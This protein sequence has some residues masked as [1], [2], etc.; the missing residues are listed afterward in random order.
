MENTVN[1]RETSTATVPP[2]A[3]K[4]KVPIQVILGVVAFVLLV[5]GG[6]V[7]FFLSQQSQDIRQQA[8]SSYDTCIAGCNAMPP[9]QAQGQ[10]FAGCSTANT[11]TPSTAPIQTCL[12][13]LNQTCSTSCGAG[14]IA[15]GSGTCNAGLTCCKPNPQTCLVVSGQTCS[16]SCGTGYS[17]GTG[18]CGGGLTCCK[19]DP[20]STLCYSTNSDCI[21]AGSCGSNGYN[22][23]T[24]AACQAALAN[25]NICTASGQCRGGKLCTAADATANKTTGSGAS[26]TNT[27]YGVNNQ[28]NGPGLCGSSD[29]PLPDRATCLIALNGITP[30]CTSVGLCI[31]Y[32]LCTAADVSKAAQSTTGSGAIC[33]PEVGQCYSKSNNCAATGACGATGGYIYYTKAECQTTTCWGTANEC[34]SR[35]YSC[36][37]P[38]TYDNINACVVALNPQATSCYSRTNNCATAGTCGATGGYIYYTKADCQ[39]YGSSCATGTKYCAATN[40]CI[41]NSATCQTAGSCVQSQG[42]CEGAGATCCGGLVCQGVAGSR[43]CQQQN[44][45]DCAPTDHC[46]GN[47]GYIGFHCTNLTNGQCNSNPQTFD[48]MEAAVAYAGT[49]GQADT[50]CAAQRNLCGGFTIFSSGC[51]PTST[52]PPASTPPGVTP[53]PIGPVCLNIAMSKPNPVVGDTVTFTCGTVAGAA[54]YEFRVKLPDGTI[55]NLATSTTS[56]NVSTSFTVNSSGSHFAQCRLCTGA[57]E[58]TCQAYSSI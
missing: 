53:T 13:S 35:T 41:A 11:P 46:G 39:N 32:H 51:T 43:L 7:A 54:R 9:G 36:T 58:S 6:G 30:K 33:T 22:Y 18:T 29:F 4:K 55:Q 25:L 10:C 26:C 12:Q 49:C 21:P 48:T 31:N 45:N 44:A 37:A 15:G 23:T 24:Q 20:S 40:S 2:A 14:M 16:T 42:S 1:I 19:Y 27:C 5:L 47:Q 52:N 38:N 28:C 56:V 34:N 17:A 3:P 50:V 8:S 57:A